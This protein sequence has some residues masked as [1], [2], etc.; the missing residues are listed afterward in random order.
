MGTSRTYE[1]RAAAVA[2]AVIIGAV[3]LVAVLID[4]DSGDTGNSF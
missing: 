2:L 4:R 1:P 3:T